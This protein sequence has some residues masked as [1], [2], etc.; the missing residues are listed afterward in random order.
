[1][2]NNEIPDFTYG[3]E[4]DRRAEPRLAIH[5]L[6]LTSFRN[7]ADLRLESGGE[8]IVLVGQNGSGKTNLLEAVSLLVPGRGLRKAALPEFQQIGNPTA[9]A[10]AARARTVTCDMRIGTGRDPDRKIETLSDKRIAHIDGRPTKSIQALAEAM[11]MAWITP[12]MD[13]ILAEGPAARR[14]FIDRL[15]CNFDPAHAGRIIRYEKAMRERLRLLREGVSDPIW[16]TALE[17]EMAKV[18]VAIAAGRLQ[19]VRQLQAGISESTGHFPRALLELRG[20]AEQTL[21]TK[22]ALLVEDEIRAA[23]AKSRPEDA[24]QNATAIGP[25]RSDLYI[26]HAEKN[27]PA[28]FCSTGEQKALLI[29]IMLSYVRS[30]IKSR[31]VLP[32]LL[33]DDIAAHLD[34]SRCDALLTE[35]NMFG[36]QIWATGTDSRH[37]STLQNSA[38]FY[39]IDN[40]TVSSL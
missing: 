29:A 3:S 4:G 11:C 23:L 20:Q 24:E 27:C 39:T 7:Y 26:V 10:V 6:S 22:A 31:K 9:W 32:I 37:F 40:G 36:L 25:H 14:K 12:E 21:Q 28:D 8:S 1:M 13:R 34:K 38:R 18:G 19:L 5:Q 16:L 2:I 33:L 30:L 17:D 35:V 15:T